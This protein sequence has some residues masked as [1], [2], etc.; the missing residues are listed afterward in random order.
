[1]TAHGLA[2]RMWRAARLDPALFEEVE[3]DRDATPQAFAVVVLA[4]LA[5]GIGSFHNGG[6]RGIA[7]IAGAWLLGWYV[8][9]RTACWVGTHLLPAAGTHADTGELLRALGFASAPCVLLA[10]ALYEPLAALVFL[11]CGLWMLLG[12]VVAVRQALDYPG[13]LR[14][15][16]V[17][18]IAFPFYAAILALALLLLGPWPV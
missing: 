15:V 17:C 9:A 13:T 8:W 18:A 16:A 1:M 6:A 5:A 14:A 7:W 2:G 12:M 10:L 11:V 4:A 3:A